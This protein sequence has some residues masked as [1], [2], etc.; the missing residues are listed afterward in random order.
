MR[1]ARRRPRHAGPPQGFLA[2]LRSFLTP[3]VLRQAHA[4]DHRRTR[5]DARWHLR[6]L[7]LAL[8]AFTWCTGDTLADRFETARAFAVSL[9]PR[10]RRPGRSLQGFRLAL[11]RLPTAVLRAVADGVRARLAAW[12][13]PCLRDQAGF[14]ALGCDG[15]RLEAP[16]TP[17]LERAL[18][19][20]GKD[21]AAPC[22]WVTALVHLR[23]GL[24]WAWR[25]GRGTASERGHLR[26]LLPALPAGALLVADAGFTG[27]GLARALLAAGVPFLI[28]ASGTTPLFTLR[29]AE[30]ARW[31]DGRVDYWPKAEQEAGAPPVPLR[32]IR[33]RSRR[34]KHD[35]WLLTSVL[36]RRRLSA[37]QAGRYYR[38][39]WECEGLF[40]SY[41]RVLGQVK[42]SGRTLTLVH[43]EAEGSLLATQ[44]LL[45]QASRALGGA[46]VGTRGA[47]TGARQDIGRRAEPYRR[48]REP[49]LGRER[50]PGRRSGK[51]SRPWPRRKPHKPPQ[52]PRLAQLDAEQKALRK[53]VLGIAMPA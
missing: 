47:L 52:P 48:R 10:R 26:A 37:T 42:L 5:G 51:A 6:P 3:D 31:R 9:A 12:L 16:R 50:R 24:L 14:C 23:T 44:L 45:A 11:T 36:E 34:H 28:R 33:L 21:Q 2:R 38:Q 20:A 25:T 29:R 15:T 13:G 22:L 41:K 53:R 43:R 8:L 39:R 1:S 4:A 32:L 46:A 17:Q 19:Q 49:E 30:R 40:R 7:L 35:V 18:G 27:Y